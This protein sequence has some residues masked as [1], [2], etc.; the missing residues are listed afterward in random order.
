M[1]TDPRAPAGPRTPAEPPAPAGPPATADPRTARRFR[2]LLYG[3]IAVFALLAAGL[4]ALNLTQGPRMTAAQL[5]VATSVERA[6]QRL[7]LQAN[8]VIAPVADAQVTVSPAA[9]VKTTTNQTSIQIEFTGILAYNTTYTVTATGVRSTS[10]DATSTF[11]YSFT[12]PDANVFTLLRGQ[13]DDRIERS[14]LTAGTGETVYSAPNISLFTTLGQKLV[15]ATTDSDGY[16]LLDIVSPDGSAASIPVQLA[17]PGTVTGLVSSA[18]SNLFGYTYRAAPSPYY[19]TS[20]DQLYIYDTTLGQ[21]YS[22]PVTGPDRELLA[23]QSWAFLPGTTSL[24]V[25][26]PGGAL[27]LVDALGL[28]DGSSAAVE[29][30]S[31]D[32]LLGFLPNTKTLVTET[33]GSASTIDFAQPGTPV[34]APFA[35]A[36][37]PPNGSLAAPATAA[38]AAAATGGPATGAAAEATAPGEPAALTGAPAATGGTGGATAAHPEPLDASGTIVTPGPDATTLQKITG[39]GTETLFTAPEGSTIIRSCLSTNGRYA[40]AETAPATAA[41]AE[42]PDVAADATTTYIPL[43]DPTA[44]R[45][46]AGSN[47]DWCSAA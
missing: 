8:E 4:V 9:E 41:A 25:Q 11:S 33:A 27:F 42:A 39:T 19:P 12:T 10:L 6:G 37:A 45:T 30:G 14:S 29:V 21:A 20:D 47:P 40:V 24:V 5:N 3:S 2:I 26:D 28:L 18:K 1:S 44:S 32:A 34:T 15:V 31:A 7:L 38:A 13:P 16:D 36:A 46:V 22:I 43:D 23:V 35:L 17:G